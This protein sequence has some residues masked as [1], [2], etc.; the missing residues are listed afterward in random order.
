MSAD[1]RPCVPVVEVNIVE[2]RAKPVC[3]EEKGFC[4]ASLTCLVRGACWKAE[5]QEDG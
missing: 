2:G 3:L 4:V 1:E 5:P